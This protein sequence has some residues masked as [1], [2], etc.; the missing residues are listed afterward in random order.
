[1]PLGAD[2]AR[3]L[4]A[5][6]VLGQ[7]GQISAGFLYGQE[8]SSFASSDLPDAGKSRACKGVL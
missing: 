3:E 4:M 5:G 7:G 6:L 1:M 8:T 2:L